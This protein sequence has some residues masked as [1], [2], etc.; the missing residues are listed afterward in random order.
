MTTRLG[1][2]S[3]FF[4]GSDWSKVDR[5]GR[6][7]IPAPFRKRLDAYGPEVFVARSFHEAFPHLVVY[8]LTVWQNIEMNIYHN[9]DLNPLEKMALMHQINRFS[10]ETAIDDRGRIMLPAEL[11]KYAGIKDTV[12]VVG[13]FDAIQIWE[14]ETYQAF[15]DRFPVKTSILNHLPY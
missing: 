14:P 4:R 15:L 3:G 12:R 5:A 7:V 11:R 8:P 6:V 9:P 2:R 13:C 1:E 10:A